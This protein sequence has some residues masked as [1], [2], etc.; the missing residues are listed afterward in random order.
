MDFTIYDAFQHRRWL[1]N[2]QRP[3]NENAGPHSHG[4]IM[5]FITDDL[6]Q[7]SIDSNNLFKPETHGLEKEP[8]VTL[9]YG[10][11]PEADTDEVL[12]FLKC[13]KNPEIKLT[14]ISLFEKDDCDVVKFDVES[15]LL[16]IMNKMC[17]MMFPYE[18]EYPDYHPHV[19]IAYVLPG[20]GKKLC[21]EIIDVSVPISYWV[22]SQADGT[23][24]RVDS[25]TGEVEVLRTKDEEEEVE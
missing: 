8:H 11:M 15:D 17:T 20:T 12:N 18:T 14:E 2:R 16:F 24:Y 21:K 23:K 19:T 25:E 7:V 22:Y 9:L 3:I 4:C 1:K 10:L 6:P 5:G 13:L